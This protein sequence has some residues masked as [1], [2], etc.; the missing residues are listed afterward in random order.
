M[1][2]KGQSG[3][4]KGRPRGATG[5]AADLTRVIRTVE[6]AD[7]KSLLEHFVKQAFKSDRVL[8]AVVKKLLPDLKAVESS[9]KSE[10]F[11]LVINY[12]D[13]DSTSPETS[14]SAAGAKG[15]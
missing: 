15:L 12:P 13:R 3:N 6:K 1:F 5:Y 2:Q 8:I 14:G 10:G 11:R 7:G 4:P 9:V